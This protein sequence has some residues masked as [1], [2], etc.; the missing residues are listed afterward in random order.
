MST[1][2]TTVSPAPVFPAIPV[3]PSSPPAPTPIPVDVGYKSTE[4]W[5]TTLTQL[6][7]AVVALAGVFGK[8]DK[9]D[10]HWAAAVNQ[11]V[12][13]VAALLAAFATN[14]QYVASRTE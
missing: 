8:S 4:F 6:V 3:E 11:M 2:E 14:R 12:P 1:G 5:Q 13:V 10:D 7:A 9:P